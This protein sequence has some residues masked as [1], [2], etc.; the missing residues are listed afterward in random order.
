[1]NKKIIYVKCVRESQI[2]KNK[3]EFN[4]RQNEEYSVYCEGEITKSSNGFAI[5]YSV[6]LNYIFNCYE[7]Y[8]EYMAIVEVEDTDLEV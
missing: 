3:D 1:M 8:G 7:K 5:L 6:P 2:A 4:E